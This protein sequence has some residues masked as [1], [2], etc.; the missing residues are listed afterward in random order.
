MST[1][2]KS[3][4]GGMEMI[5]NTGPNNTATYTSTTSFSVRCNIDQVWYTYKATTDSTIPSFSASGLTITWVSAPSLNTSMDFVGTIGTNSIDL[6]IGSGKV[7]VKGPLAS[8]VAATTV[9]GKGT[10]SSP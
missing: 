6:N 10:W 1:V 7:L 4:P 8:A 2:Q 5:I 3:G 9:S